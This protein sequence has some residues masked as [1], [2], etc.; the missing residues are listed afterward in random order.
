MEE[1]NKD[2][3]IPQGTLVT[4]KIAI[5]SLIK[6]KSICTHIKEDKISYYFTMEVILKMSQPTFIISLGPK[7]H[8]LMFK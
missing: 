8:F 4:A 2:T 1:I 3:F 5:L 7:K 6:I